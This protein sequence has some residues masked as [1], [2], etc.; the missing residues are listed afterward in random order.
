MINILHLLWIIPI[1]G[2]IGVVTTA[3]CVA[4]KWADND[5]MEQDGK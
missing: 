5:Y 1:S 2:A 4:A 3:F